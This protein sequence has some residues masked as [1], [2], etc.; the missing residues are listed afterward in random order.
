MFLVV[1]CG[2]VV[3][4]AV[5]SAGSGLRQVVISPLGVRA[6][7]DAPRL[8]WLRLAVAGLVVVAGFAVLQFT[9]TS[10]GAIGITAAM[11]GVLV[12]IM[13]VQNLAGPFLI[14]LA[15][16]RKLA[17][18]T[19]AADLI[20]ARTLLE[21]PKAAWRQVSSVAMA[22]FVVVPA[23]SVLGF[24]SAVQNGPSVLTAQQVLFFGD[25][26]IVVVAAVAVSALLAACAIGITQ[27]AGVIERRDL[28]VSLD[29]LGMPLAAMEAA[30]RMAVMIPVRIAVIGSAAVA[31]IIAIPVVAISVFTAPLF[32]FG[33]LVCIAASIWIVR[34]GVTATIPVLRSVLA[35]PERAL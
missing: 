12:A 32:I 8:H 34:L 17:T 30:R 2:A 10:W 3:L 13:A 35:H 6:R 4:V 5:V 9:S 11:I 19:G 1:L 20:A 29:R 33:V 28:Y 15:A 26:R 22:S 7:T 23:G 25:I 14:G 27:A 21:S 18:S 16:R 31:T 24:L